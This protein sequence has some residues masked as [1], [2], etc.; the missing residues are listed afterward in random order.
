MSYICEKCDGSGE[1]RISEMSTITEPCQ[2]C[3]G[4]GVQDPM[5]LLGELARVL[6]K[7]V[8][9]GHAMPERS[10]R[11]YRWQSRQE[12]QVR[13]YLDR[14]PRGSRPAFVLIEKR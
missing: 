8:I 7:E 14:A 3:K 2:A 4:L 9:Q 11:N 1:Q 5:G 10:Y 12:H 6:G 13:V